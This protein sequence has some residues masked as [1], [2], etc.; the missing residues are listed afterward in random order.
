MAEEQ[1]SWPRAQPIP[2]R[3][4]GVPVREAHLGA[5]EEDRGQGC[6]HVR[7]GHAWG[8]PGGASS[9]SLLQEPSHLMSGVL[10]IVL[11]ACTL[12]PHSVSSPPSLLSSLSP[13]LYLIF[14]LYLHFLSLPPSSLSP[15]IHFP[16]FISSLLPY[17]LCSS[18]SPSLFL[19][20]GSKAPI[21]LDTVLPWWQCG[22]TSGCAW[23]CGQWEDN[24]HGCHS[25]QAEGEEC[26]D[27]EDHCCSVS[28]D[29][30][31][32]VKH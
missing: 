13:S 31:L 10:L 4:P 29:H 24:F 20:Q 26:P 25:I 18:S 21:S 19:P 16:H 6:L 32:I 9:W 8:L 27:K 7:P 3:L 1:G 28:R 23:S 17:L 15:S 2:L 12:F 14:S 30:A 22:L 5:W 11:F